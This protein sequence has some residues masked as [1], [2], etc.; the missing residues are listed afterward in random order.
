MLLLGNIINIWLGPHVAFNDNN[1]DTMFNNIYVTWINI[2]VSEI[3][4][5]N[6]QCIVNKTNLINRVEK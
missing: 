3:L 2:Y 6:L 1:D 5:A 4:N